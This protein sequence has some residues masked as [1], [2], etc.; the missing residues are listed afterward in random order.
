MNLE[1]LRTYCLAKSDVE[2]CFPFGEVTLVYKVGGKI[3]LL[4]GMD[5]VPFSINIKA[6]PESAVE[7]RE[8]YP[9]VT[10]GYHMNKK[11]W[12]TIVLDGSVGKNLIKQWIDDSYKL[13]A[14]S[15][16]KAKRKVVG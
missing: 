10:P 5:E 9:A 14:S 16:P 15:L 1:E 3:F 2:E 11:H 7:Q 8:R 12:N 6:D 13:V 4:A